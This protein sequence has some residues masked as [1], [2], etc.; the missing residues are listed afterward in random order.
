MAGGD[1]VTRS[2]LLSPGQSKPQR[3]G[4]DTDE[5][6]KRGRKRVVNI[7]DLRRRRIIN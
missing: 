6:T 3:R 7:H 1:A 5:E 2:L 4:L